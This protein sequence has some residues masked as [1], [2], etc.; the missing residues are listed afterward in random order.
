LSTR[1]RN[2]REEREREKRRTEKREK[3][4]TE[5]ERGDMR[6]RKRKALPL[7]RQRQPGSICP[8]GADVSLKITLTAS[9]YF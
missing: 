3:R 8:C 1:A 9:V 5:R 4:G 7:S 6:T 2:L